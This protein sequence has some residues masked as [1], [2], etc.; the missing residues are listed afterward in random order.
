MQL[1]RVVLVATEEVRE[2]Q[3]PVVPVAPE[4]PLVLVVPVAQEA[5]HMRED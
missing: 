5:L 1:L 2:R 3:A 4:L